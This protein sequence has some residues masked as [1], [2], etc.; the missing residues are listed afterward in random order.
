VVVQCITESTPCPAGFELILYNGVPSVR[1]EC[2]PNQGGCNYNG[3]GLQVSQLELVHVRCPA[4][5]KL[6]AM[7]V[8]VVVTRLHSVMVLVQG[9]TIT[10]DTMQSQ[11]ILCNHSRYYASCI[12]L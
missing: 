5:S 11:Q 4:A 2:R 10:A 1:Q 9:G 6:H 12:V 3:F 7:R 8:S